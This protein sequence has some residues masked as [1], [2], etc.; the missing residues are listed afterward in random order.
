M[1]AR[2]Q[3]FLVKI[4]GLSTPDDDGCGAG[5]GRGHGRPGVPSEKPA[6]SSSRRRRL[7]SRNWRA[8]GPESWRWSSIRRL[9]RQRSW[10]GR[11][12]PDW[13]Q[14]HGSR[15]AGSGRRDQGRDRGPDHEGPGHFGSGR[16]RRDRALSQHD[17]SDPARRQAA[18]ATPP[19]RAAMAGPS[20]G[21]VLAGLDPGLRFMLSGGLDPANVGAAIAHRRGRAASM[22]P[23]AWNPR[24]ASRISAGSRISL[25]RRAPQAADNSLSVAKAA[26]T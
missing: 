6:L 16:S 3:Q 19:T 13:L 12:R 9:G 23:R 8:V 24:P 10:S 15:D 21:R 4:C 11:V 26:I 5:C 17:G 2:A 25:Q 14:L 20:T 1:N 18:E 7:R 22:S